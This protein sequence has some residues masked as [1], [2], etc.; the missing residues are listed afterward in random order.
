M[1]DQALISGGYI[2]FSR[3]LLKSGIMEKPPLY[4]KLWVW[5][6]MKASYKD[7]G[8]LKRGQFFTT[9]SEM[10]DVMSYKIG[11]RTER[12]TVKQIRC[13]YDFLTKGSMVV[14]MKVI[15]G[16]VIT[17]LNY[18]YYQDYKN[19][20]GRN[21]GNTKGEVGAQYQKRKEINNKYYCKFILKDKTEYE[22]SPEQIE[23]FKF[24]YPYV[25]LKSEFLK[26]TAWCENNK[27]KRKTRKG[28]P[29]FLNNWLSNAQ[30]RAIINKQPSIHD[31]LDSQPSIE[32]LIS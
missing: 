4:L 31:R 1:A 23:K 26:I 19:Y 32:E 7:N 2:L 27:S 28:A 12:P 8:D 17:I 24:A 25:D 15:H 11:Y 14:I 3:K 13:V 30:E 9:I 16:M 10:Q 21:E 20:E 18:D 29:R 22:L 5:M 6:L